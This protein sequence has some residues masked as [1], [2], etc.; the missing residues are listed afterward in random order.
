MNNDS[1][2]ERKQSPVA[3]RLIAALKTSE[4]LKPLHVDV[5]NESYWYANRRKVSAKRHLKH[6]VTYNQ[7]SLKW[8]SYMYK[9]DI[10]K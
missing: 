9:M 6:I 5:R 10:M 7:R 8:E 3:L 2:F 4:Y 1:S